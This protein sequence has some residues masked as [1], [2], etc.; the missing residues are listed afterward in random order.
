MPAERVV[1]AGSGVTGLACA[2]GFA[3]LGYPVTLCGDKVAPYT[4][5]AGDYDLRVFALNDTS[6]AL[7]ARLGAWDAITA[8][9]L[10][11]YEAMEVWAGRGR[12]KFHATDVARARLG[13][14]VENRLLCG[15]LFEH[16]RARREVEIRCPARF[17][18]MQPMTAGRGRRVAFDDG[19]E[20][21]AALVIGADGAGSR[22]R[23]HAGV[24]YR[25][26]AYGQDALVATVAC[27]AAH[28]NVCLQRFSDEGITAFLPLADA[29]RNLGSIVWS[30][31]KPLAADLAALSREAFG[32]RLARA[33]EHRLGAMTPV[34]ERAAFP[35]YGALA[36]DYVAAGVALVGD[37]AHSVHPLAGQGANMGLADV[38]VLLDLAA[39]AAD[40]GAH[41]GWSALRRYQRS[42]KGRNLGVKCALD[43][44]RRGFAAGRTPVGGLPAAGLTLV[45]RCLPLKTW[46]IN[47]AA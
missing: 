47:K 31:D 35:L 37:A 1:V 38:R 5:V 34:S 28:G 7:L 19:G 4:G 22:V 46:F 40:A 13:V 42:V 39:S 3:Q 11:P 33:L 36:D 21:E 44:I 8:Q 18:S 12:L 14:I 9:R 17:E 25:R 15:V 30:C 26:R 32:A 29:A 45:D 43:A 20:V 41:V 16:L 10:C 27:E 23:A 6:C 24:G 2:A